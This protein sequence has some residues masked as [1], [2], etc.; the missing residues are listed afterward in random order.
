[1]IGLTVL[2][3]VRVVPPFIDVQV[4]VYPVI[5]L[6]P[7]LAGGVNGTVAVVPDSV[8]VPI[9]GAPGTVAGTT[10]FDG[11]DAGPVPTEFVAATVHV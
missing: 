2:V 1:M 5:E 4:T 11:S 6:P 7:L 8:T 9:V 3:P 10:L